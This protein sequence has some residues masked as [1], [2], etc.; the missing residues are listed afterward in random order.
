MRR[1]ALQFHAKWIE[2]HPLSTAEALV[3]PDMSA[4]HDLGETFQVIAKTRVFVFS[5]RT[6]FTVWFAGLLPMIP[7][8][9]STLT[10]E[11]VLQ[12]IVRTVLG[13]LPL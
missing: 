9:V 11:Q 4:L 12:R 6:V 3:A 5:P 8:F 13:G 7:L 10:V 1:F 2:H